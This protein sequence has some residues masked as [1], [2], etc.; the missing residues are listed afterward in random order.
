M[1]AA[2]SHMQPKYFSASF[3]AASLYSGQIVTLRV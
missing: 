3:M 1:G 2:F